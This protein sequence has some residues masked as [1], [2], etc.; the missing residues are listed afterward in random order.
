MKRIK[1]AC[2][3][4]TIHF[5]KDEG[6]DSATAKKRIRAELAHFKVQL[7][8]SQIR[9]KI[10][11]EIVQPDGSIIL[12]IDRQFNNYDCGDYLS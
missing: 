2:L 8:R 7:K 10:K 6:L 12:K 3:Q 11:D 9:Y 1:Y 4:Q 5:K